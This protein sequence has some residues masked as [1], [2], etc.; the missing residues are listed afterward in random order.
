MCLTVACV[1][2]TSFVFSCPFSYYRALSHKFEDQETKP[3]CIVFQCYSK[4][5]ITNEGDPFE[6]LK[7]TVLSAL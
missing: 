6:H 3:Q 5:K 2:N 7:D 1:K 4:M